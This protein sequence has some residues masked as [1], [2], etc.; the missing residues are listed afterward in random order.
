MRWGLA[1]LL[2]IIVGA[3]LAAEPEGGQ[4]Y[5]VIETQ[6]GQEHRFRVE[7]AQDYETQR[8]GLMFRDQLAD[9]Q[10][11]LFIFDELDYVHFWMRNTLIPLD[12]IFIRNG[13]IDQIETRRDT[14]SD[15]PTSS[16]QPVDSVLEINAGRAAA[17]GLGRGDRVLLKHCEA[18]CLMP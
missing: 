13:T 9:D 16:L 10:G 14:Q 15:R 18:P 7:L 12:M 11:M 5:V 8:R 17:L 1:I 2:T 3:G 4:D 6:A